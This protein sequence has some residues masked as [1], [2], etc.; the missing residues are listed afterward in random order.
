[1]PQFCKPRVVF[2]RC[3]GFDH[4]R[5]NGDIINDN[6]I[7]RLKD[8]CHALTPCP[9]VEIGLGIPREPIRIIEDDNKNSY[10]MQPAT[11]RD[12]SLEM[13]KYSNRYLSNL[14]EVDGF[15]LKAKSP[16]CGR[17]TV[18]AYHAVN[19]KIPLSTKTDGF[20]ARAVKDNYPL[21]PFEDEG[22]L[23]NYVLRER[24][25]TQIFTLASFRK[26]A[27]KESFNELQLF[28]AS[29]KELLRFYNQQIKIKMGKLI[30]DFT[31]GSPDIILDQYGQLLKEAM[32]SH[33]RPAALANFFEHALGFFK[34][35]LSSMDKQLFLDNVSN[36]KEGKLPVSAML[37][38]IRSWALHFE[39]NWLLEQTILQPYPSELNDI[40]DSGKGRDL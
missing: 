30:G 24:F 37:T 12:H 3:L 18:K 13:L 28:H 8:H 4:C 34:N 29:N 27:E 32:A 6:F 17:G 19:D 2:S 36:W 40:H 21:T 10:L 15:I 31:G 39:K 23:N 11:G 35:D 38:M 1:M 14:G 9:E 33:P 20:F 26:V 16:S 5:Y 22:R 25:L 7:L